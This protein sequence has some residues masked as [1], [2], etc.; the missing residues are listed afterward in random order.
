MDAAMARM[1]GLA[2]ASLRTAPLIAVALLWEAFARAHIVS[3]FLLPPFSGVVMRLLE[4]LFSGDLLTGIALTVYRALA[5]FALAAVLGVAT[6]ILMAR[7]TA[8]RWLFDPLVSVGLPM[9]KIAFLPVFILWF[10]VFDAS[11]ILMVA[12]SAVFPVIVAAT[13]AAEGVDR[14]LLWSARSLGASRRAI[15]WE[16]ALPA[17]SP[18]IVTGL[19]VA[20]PISLIVAVVAE[21]AMGGEGLGGTIMT[22]M[23]FADSPG[24]FA[25]IIAIAA[26]GSLLIK[27]LELVR[28]RVL[29]W[30]AET[31]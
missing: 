28:R 10:G 29:V 24:V 25:G 6:G 21:M 23:R 22:E 16:I 15:L 12:F 20:L 8:M 7:V 30:Q 9:P 1:T 18:Q 11:K 31:A 5:G 19:Q 3:D 2:E 13:A 4:D 26:V 14:A 17:A 27:V